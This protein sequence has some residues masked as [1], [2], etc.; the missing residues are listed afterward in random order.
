MCIRDRHVPLA[1]IEA[2]AH[3]IGA[4]DTCTIFEDLGIEQ[5]PHSTLVSYLQRLIW[6]FRGSWGRPGAMYPHSNLTQLGGGGGGKKR[7]RLTPVTGAQIISGLVPCNTI[8]KEILTDH[9]DRFRAMIVESANPVHS[10][11]ESDSFRAALRALDFS[12][13]ID[14]A[15]TE[16]AREADYVLPASSQYEKPES[17]FFTHEFPDLS[18]IHI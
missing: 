15:M 12:V 3:R 18:L 16:T 14:V 7:E 17:V 6:I 11:S 1:D 5:A 8:A 13:V 9:P 10:L 4:A 2:V